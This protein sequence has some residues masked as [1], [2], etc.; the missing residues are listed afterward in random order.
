MANIAKTGKQLGKLID[1]VGT[2]IGYVVFKKVNGEL[3]KM[4]FHKQIP[5]RFRNGGGP[6]YD[7]KAH[8]L[9]WVRDILIM[10]GNPV[11]SVKW[12]AVVIL[13]VNNKTY[14]NK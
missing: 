13:T 1:S 8:R 6:V 2:R 9:S 4:W 12:D 10:E 7:P 11:R 5:E 3:R 14:R